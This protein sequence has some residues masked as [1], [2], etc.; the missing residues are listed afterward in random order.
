MKTGRRLLFCMLFC[1][2]L[3]LAAAPA[4]RASDL[5][6]EAQVNVPYVVLFG[7]GT[8]DVGGLSVASYRV[9][10][11]HTFTLGEGKE[12]LRLKFTG[13]I[14]YSHADFETS[15]LGPKLTASQDYIFLLPQAE[16]KIP[17][18]E[19]W[20]LKPYLAAGA[21]YAF[22]G[23]S[24][25]EGL[26]KQ[27]VREGYDFIYAAG[28]SSLYEFDLERFSM[29]FGAR[30]GWAEDVQLGDG[31]DQGYA[32]IQAGVEV[33]HPL[34]VNLLGRPLDLAGSFI[35]YYFFPA[36][37]FTIPGKHSLEISNQY[38]FGTTLGFAEP[39]ELWFLDNP[40][41]GASY[42]FGDGLTGFRVNLGFPF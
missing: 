41:I 40:R 36:A 34:G 4:P 25:L 22:N 26:P 1:C 16:L 12:P 39:T 7:F 11:A 28:I 18:L 13:Y 38:E 10:I 5:V 17:L 19:G 3:D 29:S 21:G 32:T 8:Y 23:Y 14:G 35:Y 30:L 9:P 20:L 27:A 37:Q 42:R 6:I 15:L 33:R 24:K 2:F 31:Q